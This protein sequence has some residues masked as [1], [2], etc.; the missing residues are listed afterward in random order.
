MCSSC[1]AHEEKEWIMEGTKASPLE[2]I[3][4]LPVALKILPGIVHH[5]KSQVL[6]GLYLEITQGRPA[7][8][9]SKAA[10]R[11]GFHLQIPWER[12]D[13][14]AIQIPDR[15]GLSLEIAHREGKAHLAL[16]VTGTLEPLMVCSHPTFGGLLFHPVWESSVWVESSKGRGL[17]PGVSYFISLS[18]S[19]WSFVT[20]GRDWGIWA[21]QNGRGWFFGKMF[22]QDFFKNSL[23]LTVW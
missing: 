8:L 5:L 13:L 7:Y 2:I 1:S 21:S 18:F 12:P 22:K 3:Q 15:P 17:C 14:P 20:T 9:E 6:P 4:S 19:S 10:R 23:F 16:E 11:P